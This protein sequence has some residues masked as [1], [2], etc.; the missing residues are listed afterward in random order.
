MKTSTDALVMMI[1]FIKAVLYINWLGKIIM[2]TAKKSILSKLQ[3]TTK[4]HSKR[5]QDHMESSFEIRV[6]CGKIKIKYLNFSHTFS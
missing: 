6:L 2:K 4:L 3:C 5:V 1:I